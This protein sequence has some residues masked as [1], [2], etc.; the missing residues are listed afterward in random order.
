M[1]RGA[2]FLICW[3]LAAV[4]AF[5][6]VGAIWLGSYWLA[7]RTSAPVH[8]VGAHARW[9][10][11]GEIGVAFALIGV[12]LAFSVGRRTAGVALAAT[13]AVTALLGFGLGLGLPG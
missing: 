11:T 2:E 9:L 10:G 3:S 12:W 13:G 4:A 5:R 7:S 6:G 8:Y 1:K